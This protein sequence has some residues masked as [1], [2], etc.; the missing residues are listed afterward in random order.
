LAACTPAASDSVGDQ[1]VLEPTTDDRSGARTLDAPEGG[2]GSVK[3]S[4]GKTTNPWTMKMEMFTD[5]SDEERR[6]LNELVSGKRVKFV[7][8]DDIIADGA[9]SGLCHVSLR[10]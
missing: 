5:F 2:A 3:G 6:R 7:A 1:T 9:H 8:G 4:D 10:R